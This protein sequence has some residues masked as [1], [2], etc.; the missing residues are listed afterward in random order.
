MSYVI[1]HGQNVFCIK[2]KSDLIPGLENKDNSLL[3]IQT[4][5]FPHHSPYVT[6]VEIR[7][8]YLDPHTV[9]VG[10]RLFRNTKKHKIA[11]STCLDYE[12]INHGKN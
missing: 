12:R 5:L 2:Q 6:I 1:M 4:L 7:L 3:L 11:F 10:L 9:L 8:Q